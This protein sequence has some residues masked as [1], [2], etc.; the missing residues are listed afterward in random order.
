ML[1][2]VSS[3]EA[4]LTGLSPSLAH[5]LQAPSIVTL[6][7]SVPTCGENNIQLPPQ[8]PAPSR[9]LCL[10]LHEE[11]GWPTWWACHLKRGRGSV[12]AS[13]HPLLSTIQLSSN[14]TD[15]S[16][17]PVSLLGT[18]SLNLFLI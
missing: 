18:S 12:M 13:G 9:L 3:A 15:N 8:D 7:L 11:Q 2:A 5:G 1:L 16:D 14:K 17:L 6:A 10:D 4:I